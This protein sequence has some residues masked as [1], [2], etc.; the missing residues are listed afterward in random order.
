M[1]LT[2]LVVRLPTITLALWGIVLVVALA[3]LR[4][5]IAMVL[6]TVAATVVIV[7]RHAG[8]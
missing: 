6:L 3:M 7:A 2:I 8:F 1:R 5:I 4:A